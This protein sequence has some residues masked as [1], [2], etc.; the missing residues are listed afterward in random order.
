MRLQPIYDIAEVCYSH[1]ITNAV[2]CPGSRCAPLTLAFSRHPHIKVRTFSDERS[3]AFVALG[4]AQQSKQ[5][6]VLICTSG[7]AAYNFAPAVAEA[8]YS[9]TP[10]LILT[11]DRPNEWIDQFDGQTIRQQNIYGRHAKSFYQLPEDYGHPDAVW[12]L[13]RA[14]NEA[15]LLSKRATQGPVHINVPLREPLYPQ[16]GEVTAF[17]STAKI[18]SEEKTTSSLNLFDLERIQ[19]SLAV[20]KKIVLVA[21]Q[22]DADRKVSQ[23]LQRLSQK[24]AVVIVGDVISNL[25]G[26]PENIRHADSFLAHAPAEIKSSL[27]PDILITI[28]KSVIA[29]QVK[30]FLRQYKPKEHWHIDPAPMIADTYQALTHVLRYDP[31][32]MLENISMLPQDDQF[33]QQKRENFRSLWLAEEHRAARAIQD[34]FQQQE[35]TEFHLVKTVIGALPERSHLHLANSMTVR[36]ANY[37]GLHDHQHSL[38]VHSN[39]GTSGIDGCTS[40]TVGH[41][42]ENP[43]ELQVLITGDLAFFYDRNAFWHNYLV[44]SL[45]VVVLNNHGGVILGMIDGPGNLPEADELFITRQKL[46]ARALCEEFNIEYARID[47]VRKIAN[48]LED[49][50]E[51]ST[52]AKLIEINSDTTTARAVFQKF[53]NVLKSAYHVHQ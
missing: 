53:K 28:G 25:H 37:V 15:I 4:I 46:S 38:T 6:V 2:V 40:T 34:F 20:H 22:L 18:I 1:G 39:R 26:M 16:A 52:H 44:P 23:V 36:Y 19:A 21:G 10:L 51:P 8:F 12:Y 41:A 17:S 50:F 33:G 35:L 3:A 30:L 27:Q 49:F 43:G 32:F 14:I 29:K 9:A 11:A 47:N 24:H 48:V 31:F 7:S 42:L 13:H 5:P 45:R